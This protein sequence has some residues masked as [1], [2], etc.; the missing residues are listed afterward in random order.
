MFC[1]K[2]IGGWEDAIKE[3]VSFTGETES[4]LEIRWEDAIAKEQPTPVSPPDQ[5][6]FPAPLPTSTSSMR[7]AVY[8]LTLVTTSKKAPC[9]LFCWLNH[10]SLA[11][12]AIRLQDNHSSSLVPF[13]V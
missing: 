6:V 12:C 10:W 13:F 4:D 7:H 5:A 11:Q 1:Y 3:I 2:R 8:T 9:M